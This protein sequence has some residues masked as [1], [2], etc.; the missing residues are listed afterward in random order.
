MFSHLGT[1]RPHV[2]VKPPRAKAKLF[3]SDTPPKL[4]WPSG[5][6]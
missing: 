4:G 6:T 3:L 2:N 1:S 5:Q